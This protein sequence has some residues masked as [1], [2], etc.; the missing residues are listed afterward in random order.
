MKKFI[1]L[2]IIFLFIHSFCLYADAVESFEDDPLDMGKKKPFGMQDRAFEIGLVNLNFNFANNF[3]TIKDVF[4]DVISIDIDKLSDGFKLNLGLNVT[5]FY[6][7]FK[8]KK[9]W[10]FGLTTNME[11]MGIFGLSGNMLTISKAK[12]DNSD[13]SGALFASAT[14][15]ALFDIWKLK[16]NFNPSFFY[17]LA[18]I[19]HSDKSKS[20]LTYT[21]DY[22]NNSTVMCID[23]DILLY[24]GFPLDSG[25]G[26]SLTSKPGV[27]FSIGAEYQLAKELGLS[28]ILPFLDFDVSVNFIHV[29]LIASRIKDYTQMTGRFGDDK[30]PITLIGGDDNQDGSDFFSSFEPPGEP[31]KGTKEVDVYRPFKMITRLD[32]RPLFG[33]RL[34]TVSPVFGFCV[35]NLY[36]DPFSWE[37]GLNACLNL[38]NFFMVKV[39]L[40]Y[41]DR[42]YINSLGIALNLRAFELDLGADIRSQD[43]AQS[44]TGGGL[45]INFGLKF[46]W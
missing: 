7:S 23:Y 36:N 33:A 41:T 31:V 35:N 40:N 15:N 20:G 46:G 32:W 10:G 3:L 4:Q 17:T 27:D 16:F 28:K 44:W 18:Y 34:L 1:T 39:G 14:V 11:T 45:G 38:A 24:T 2:L 12:E 25:A 9:G 42:M 26:F 8:S 30:N 13:I 43:P 22:P 19:T 21:L 29:P 37:L 6:F 5:P